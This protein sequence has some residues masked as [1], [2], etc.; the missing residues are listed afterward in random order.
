MKKVLSI[1]NSILVFCLVIIILILSNIYLGLNTIGRLVSKENMVNTIKNIDIVEVIGEDTKK[2][3]YKTLGEAGIPTEYVDSM[4]ENE[5]I[6]KTIGEYV[7]E[8]FDYILGSKEIP[9]INEKDF[10]KLLHETFD[11]AVKEV[12]NNNI[13]TKEYL[14]SEKQNMVHEKI[15]E[16]VPQII[17]AEDFI[18]EKIN[19]NETISETRNEFYEMQKNIETFQNIYQKR[20]LFLISII[21]LI[22]IITA[23]KFT[24]LKFIGWF[25]FLGIL[26]SFNFLLISNI[27]SLVFSNYLSYDMIA[28]K[29]II[30]PSIQL[31]ESSYLNAFVMSFLLTILLISINIGSMIYKKKQLN[32]KEVA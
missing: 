8:S 6:K 19:E 26:C 28:L 31:L 7:A 30:E 24:K 2:E 14:S 3:I 17:E 21:I 15:D 23:L 1:L 20:N 4:L 18:S 32:K 12:E 10:S 11:K 5:E 22:I 29:N 9:T 25:I 13:Q 16:Y 27:I